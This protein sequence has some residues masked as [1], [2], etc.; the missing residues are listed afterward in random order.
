ML[1]TSLIGGN[2][3]TVVIGSA[4]GT[5][6]TDK[7]ITKIGNAAFID[8]RNLK[9]ILIPKNITHIGGGA[10]SGCIN[11]GS[12]SYEGTVAEWEDVTL[13]VIWYTGYSVKNIQCT[14]GEVAIEFD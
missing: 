14:D 6:P 11:I 2:R 5:I 8:R 1:G 3:D 9:H 4:D 13:G 7:N 10:F 12:I